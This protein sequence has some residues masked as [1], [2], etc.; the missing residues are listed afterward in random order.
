MTIMSPKV[1]SCMALSCPEVKDLSPG[2][3]RGEGM[4]YENRQLHVC[5]THPTA[6]ERLPSVGGLSSVACY[7]GTI[8]QLNLHNT[9]GIVALIQLF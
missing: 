7:Q 8:Q 2:A 9:I 1:L 5:M 3:Q 6:E 4:A